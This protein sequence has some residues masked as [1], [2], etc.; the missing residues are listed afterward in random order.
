MAEKE[1]REVKRENGTKEEGRTL[2]RKKEKGDFFQK[3]KK[4]TATCE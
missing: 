4:I 1:K 3:E 2:A